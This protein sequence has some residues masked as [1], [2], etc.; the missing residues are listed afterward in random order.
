MT[1]TYFPLHVHT[2]Y[3]LMDGLSKPSQ[4]VKRCKTAN[5]AG[6]AMTDHGNIAGAIAFSDAM[7]KAGLKPIIGVEFYVCHEPPKNKENRKLTHLLILAKNKQGWKQLI[8]LTS[9]ANKPDNF[10][11]K[12]R[13]SIHELAKYCDGNLIGISGHMG[14]CMSDVIFSDVNGAACC[15]NIKDV[16]QFIDAGYKAKSEKK[17]L[18]LEGVFGK[19]N[20]FLEVQLIDKER[21]PA[22]IVLSTIYEEIG[23]ALGIPRVATPDAHYAS[24]EDAI[25]Q[26]ILLCNS[27]NITMKQVKQK[28]VKGDD[29]ALG[30]FFQS[31]NY[32]I[33]SFEDMLAVG[34]TSDQLENT[35]M[36][37]DMCETYQLTAKPTLPIYRDSGAFMTEHQRDISSAQLLREKC[38]EGWKW[39]WPKIKMVIESTSHTK[40]EY[41]DRVESELSVLEGVQFENGSCLSDYFLIV[42]DIVLNSIKNGQLVGAGR[43]SAAGSLVLYL[44]GVTHID[45]IEFDL[46]FERFYNAGRNTA[47]RVS[48]PDVDMDFQIT[49]R[50]EII[51]YIRQRFGHSKVAQ[52]LTFTRMQGRS[53]LKDV[54]RAWDACSYSEMNDI[55]R[56]IPDEAE[57]SDQLQAMKEADKEAG[58]DG[59]ASIIMW[60]LEHHSKELSPWVHLDDKGNIQGEYARQFEQAIRLEGTKRSQ[61]KHAAGLIISCFNL[62]EVC[63]MVYDKTSGEMICGME[64]NDLEAAGHVKYDILGVAMLD[65]V[66]GWVELMEFGDFQDG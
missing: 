17:A 53:A 34:H 65:K 30:S 27:L 21:M 42:Q 4:I 63:P 22:T 39:R 19:G 12:P 26:R 29:V 58:G 18:E 55:T 40:Q 13:L 32:H 7:T 61:S 66:K 49:K 28:M 48:L 2:H 60:A 5:L 50:G 16:D 38:R 56:H 54:L 64:M 14:S 23:E 59:E 51:D 31:N 1:N 11:Y 20:F 35:N 43:G 3:S 8:K 52:M 10:Y 44:L 46:L 6:S 15:R 57:I 9:E 33:P 24:R 41:I 47:E 25:D 62:A 36:I 45:P 37:A